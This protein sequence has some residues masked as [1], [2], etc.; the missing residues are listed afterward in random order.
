MRGMLSFTILWLLSKRPMYGQ[1]LA[2][3]IG[4]RR[5]GDKPNP[6]TIYPA[7]KDL[8]SRGIIEAHPEGRNQ[9]YRLTTRGEAG[10]KNALQY[11]RMAFGE[12]FLSIS[13]PPLAASGGP[14]RGAQQR[15]Q[16]RRL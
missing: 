7:L 14:R 9:V 3:E 6:G 15:P 12:I 10:L 2:A 8:A 16:P 4:K 5:G 13:D 1:E 11:F